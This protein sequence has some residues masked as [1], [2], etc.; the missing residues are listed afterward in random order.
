MVL[1]NIQVSSIRSPVLASPGSF[2]YLPADTSISFSEMLLSP[3]DSWRNEPSVTNTGPAYSGQSAAD[4]G[5]IDMYAVDKLLQEADAQSSHNT[6]PASSKENAS[7][8]DS[9]SQVSENN[10]DDPDDNG[11][12]RAVDQRA[13]SMDIAVSLDPGRTESTPSVRD[14]DSRVKTDSPVVV[15]AE[16]V[17]LLL[18][19][20]RSLT[21][22]GNGEGSEAEKEATG[23]ESLLRSALSAGSDSVTKEN[24]GEAV[25]L[26]SEES[27]E[28]SASES[29]KKQQAQNLADKTTGTKGK[30]SL[31]SQSGTAADT[32]ATSRV[33]TAA[34]SS[35]AGQGVQQQDDSRTDA[36]SQSSATERQTA[37]GKSRK[38][39]LQV[40]DLRETRHAEQADKPSR[41]ERF[42]AQLRSEG[43]SSQLRVS[44]SGSAENHGGS[45]SGSN[46]S[47]R[48]GQ[49]FQQG[50]SLRESADSWFRGG[51]EQSASNTDNSG[52]FQSVLQRMI[53]NPSHMPMADSARLLGAR[54]QEHLNSDI[55]KQAKFVLKDGDAGEIRLRLRPADLG[56]VHIQLDLQDNVIAARI[57]VENSSVRQVFEQQMAELAEAF[58]EAGLDLGSV[59]VSVNNGETSGEHQEPG[60]ARD[61]ARV[62]AADSDRRGIEALGDSVQDLSLLYTPERLINLM[63]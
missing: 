61:S 58:A 21:G 22:S 16:A 3:A 44:S 52:A 24:T 1:E 40:V 55:V 30:E 34:D 14:R 13:R 12:D 42:R 5:Y 23:A 37:D 6:D 47:G 7:G 60:Q 8:Q 11:S 39:V 10:I 19:R 45:N 33:R 35:Q 41:I 25:G 2:G 57:F 9:D 20:S 48:D 31:D 36:G 17:S 32:A 50:Q 51:S 27:D 4:A 15:D 53:A 56:S 29:R 54:M 28:S 26:K 46:F 49:Q 59:E 18:E 62:L 38:S 43:G 63:A